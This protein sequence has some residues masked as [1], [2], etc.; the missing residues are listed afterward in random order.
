MFEL[1]VSWITDKK[2]IRPTIALS[3]FT[4][5]V[6]SLFFLILIQAVFAKL[7]S[8]AKYTIKVNTE[9]VEYKP[10]A[11]SIQV[12]KLPL[13]KVYDQIPSC[14]K[15]ENEKWYSEGEL[16]LF[17]GSQLIIRLVNEETIELNIHP[18]NS[19]SLKLAEVT[20]KKGRCIIN[21]KLTIDIR[22][23]ETNPD[24]IMFMSGNVTVGSPLSYATDTM[25]S[26]LKSGEIE[27]EDKSFWFDNLIKLPTIKLSTGDTV[28]IPSNSESTAIGLL[29]AHYNEKVMQGVYRRQGGSVNII[30][31]FSSNNGTPI[32]INFFERLYSDNVL[33]VALTISLILIHAL[34]FLVTTLIRVSYIPSTKKDHED[35]DVNYK[36]NIDD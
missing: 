23:S 36:G 19:E 32:R 1:I 3:L 12:T 16:K 11:S 18:V 28:S 27:I 26:F 35:T 22:L 17:E 2:L 31:P 29:T 25:P 8:N 7:D 6:I 4:L 15:I 20:S 13:F 10:Y 14:S 5:G 9:I 21:D 33:G 34:M 24:F 30:K